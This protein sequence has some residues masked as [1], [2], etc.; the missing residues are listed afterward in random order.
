MAGQHAAGFEGSDPPERCNQVIG[1]LMGHHRRGAGRNIEIT[2]EHGPAERLEQ[3]DVSLRVAG[4]RDDLEF[5][6]SA[7]DP[8][9]HSLGAYQPRRSPEK[10]AIRQEMIK[11]LGI[12]VFRPRDKD[13]TIVL[14]GQF[15]RIAGVVFV[16]MRAAYRRDRNILEGPKNQRAGVGKAGVYQQIPDL[17]KADLKTQHPRPPAVKPIGRDPI[18]KVFHL[19]RG[20]LCGTVETAQ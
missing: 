9:G 19:D 6:V 13:W 5:G 8:F 1:I 16:V 11:S 7:N 15:N 3:G 12:K 14:L 20:L 2:D 10:T 17:I 18:P 4:R